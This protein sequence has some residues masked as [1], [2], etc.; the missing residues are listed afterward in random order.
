MARSSPP[1]W[2][3]KN[4]TS[5]TK[6]DYAELKHFLVRR[7]RSHHGVV[8]FKDI[9]SFICT[10]GNVKVDWQGLL[11]ICDKSD[12]E[13]EHCWRPD[14]WM[15][16]SRK[17]GL[18]FVALK[19]Q[20]IISRGL[21]KAAL[22]RYAMHFAGSDTLYGVKVSRW[23]VDWDLRKTFFEIKKL[24][25][26]EFPHL[27]VRPERKPLSQTRQGN[28]LVDDYL[29]KIRVEN[30]KNNSVKLLSAQEVADWLEE[31]EAEK[32]ESGRKLNLANLKLISQVAA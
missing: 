20:M 31:L 27:S 23:S 6:R 28:W 32:P 25:K 1:E 5:I 26:R 9:G 13:Q 24:C 18:S 3:Q 22:A 19:D 16:S 15:D 11:K 4:L 17:E 8:S 21:Y 30:E 12:Q 29:L 7:H 10:R 2:A 14:Y